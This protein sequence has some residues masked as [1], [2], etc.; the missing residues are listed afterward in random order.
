MA[1][2]EM[3]S[4]L[5]F[6]LYCQDSEDGSMYLLQCG[7][8]KTCEPRVVSIVVKSEGGAKGERVMRIVNE[9]L[10]NVAM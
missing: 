2:G 7:I 9:S 6:F 5:K 10:G 3:D 8:D 4:E 1:S